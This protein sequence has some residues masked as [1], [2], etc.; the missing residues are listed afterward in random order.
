MKDGTLMT[1][2]ARSVFE[3]KTVRFLILYNTVCPLFVSL[4]LQLV[5]AMV[6][7]PS[8][9][10]GALDTPMLLFIEFLK[11]I[12][13]FV[14]YAV[15]IYGVLVMKKEV[16]PKLFLVNLLPITLSTLSS[17]L[18]CYLSIPSVLFRY[19]LKIILGNLSLNFILYIIS[20]SLIL[21]ASLIMGASKSKENL[22]LD[23]QLFSL[24]HP[25]L[26][27]LSIGTLLAVS[28]T[29]ITNVW[30]TVKDFLTYGSPKN[31]QEWIYTLTPYIELI[32]YV[33]IGY[34]VMTLICYRLQRNKK[35]WETGE[36]KA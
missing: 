20:L 30:Q 9:S 14:G 5:H 18:V 25:V 34:T 1:H 7:S 35:Q 24:R 8:Q 31:T 23:G 33:V 12:T 16:A 10:L 6:I 29:I 36:E 3:E 32:V 28:T 4:G 22:T 15:M 2:S 26:Q 27:T 17:L 21:L 11:N 13:P 19:N